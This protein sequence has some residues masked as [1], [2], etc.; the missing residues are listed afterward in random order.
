MANVQRAW[1][2]IVEQRAQVLRQLF[3]G[4]EAHN[5]QAAGIPKVR[6]SRSAA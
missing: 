1:E 2:D 6:R 4:E 3:V 5:G